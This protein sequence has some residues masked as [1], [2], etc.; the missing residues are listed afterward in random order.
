MFFYIVWYIDGHV[1]VDSAD[2]ANLVPKSSG[3]VFFSDHKFFE[4]FLSVRNQVSVI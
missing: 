2:L 3:Y 4:F 1:L